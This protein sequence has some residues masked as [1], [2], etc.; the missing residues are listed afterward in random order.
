MSDKYIMRYP[1][2]KK[3]DVIATA[4]FCAG[5]SN[6]GTKSSSGDDSFPHYEATLSYAQQRDRRQAA[7]VKYFY[8]RGETREKTIDCSLA[9][10]APKFN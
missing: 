1:R 2:I 5:I 3:C 9:I 10:D 7:A 4:G 6:T 8:P